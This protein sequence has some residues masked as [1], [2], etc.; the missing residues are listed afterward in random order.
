MPPAGASGGGAA[1]VDQGQDLIVT[2][3]RRV[4]VSSG[5]DNRVLE[6]DL[7]GNYVGD[8]VDS[9]SGLVFPTGL[10]LL[11]GGSLLVASR[12]SNDVRSFDPVDGTPLGRFILHGMGGLAGPKDELLTYDD[13]VVPEGRLSDELRAEQTAHF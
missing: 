2:P 4:L 6:F 13:V 7:D 10:L 11:P 1:A 5:G 9:A 3:D 12:D 8:L